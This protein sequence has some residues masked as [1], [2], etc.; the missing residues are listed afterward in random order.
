[1]STQIENLMSVCVCVCV[2]VCVQI[3]TEESTFSPTRPVAQ[4]PLKPAL[5]RPSVGERATNIPTGKT[6]N[7]VLSSQH[8][9]EDLRGRQ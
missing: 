7:S 6:A 5:K 1:M 4:K 9:H 3:S 8:V 2:C